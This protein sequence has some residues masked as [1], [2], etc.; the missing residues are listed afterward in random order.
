MT[1]FTHK[2][3]LIEFQIHSESKIMHLQVHLKISATKVH[4]QT[5]AS[6]W[7]V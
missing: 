7:K 2:M 5:L 1:N 6:K 3:T 4:L